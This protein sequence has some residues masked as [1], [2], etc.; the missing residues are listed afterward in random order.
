MI[1]IICGGRGKGKTK[2][3]L[4]RANELVK[5]ADGDIIYIDKSSKHMYEVNNKIRLV[6]IREYPIKSYDG[7]IGFVSGLLSGNHDIETVFFDSL[8]QISYSN[9]ETVSALIDT[10]DKL[11]DGITFVLSISLSENELPDD[12]KDKVV[13]SL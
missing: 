12:I 1:Q 10:L 4:F 2:E 5:Q 3:M 9:E 8:L 6:N 11:S 7:F 13:V